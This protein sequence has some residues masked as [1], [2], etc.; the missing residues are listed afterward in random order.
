MECKCIYEKI[1]LGFYES[2]SEFSSELYIY[3]CLLYK[4][5]NTAHEAE[6][7]QY[8]RKQGPQY[9]TD[10]SLRIFKLTKK[11]GHTLD[12]LLSN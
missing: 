6:S 2:I 12:C 11:Y 4:K 7:T 9:L 5:D 1:D 3:F 8:N 10:H